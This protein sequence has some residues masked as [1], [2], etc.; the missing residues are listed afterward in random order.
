[1]KKYKDLNIS[2]NEF[3]LI[4]DSENGSIHDY[5]YFMWKHNLI[6]N[7]YDGIELEGLDKKW[8]VNKDNFI[9]KLRLLSEIE[10]LNLMIE[11]DSFWDV[12][13]EIYSTF[14][15]ISPNLKLLEFTKQQE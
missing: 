3:H 10:F 13:E 12:K 7:I 11:V 5:G 1:M 4:C 9:D 15:F 8:G 2:K 14:G 6:G